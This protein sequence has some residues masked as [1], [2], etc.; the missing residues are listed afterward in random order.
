MVSARPAPGPASVLLGAISCKKHDA[1]VRMALVPAFFN[2]QKSLFQG[3]NPVKKFPCSIANPGRGRG[4][5]R[6]ALPYGT[7]I[8]PCH[9]A[10]PYEK[11]HEIVSKWASEKSLS[12]FEVTPRGS[13]QFYVD[14]DLS[15]RPK[16]R[17][18]ADFCIIRARMR[19]NYF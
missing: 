7:A 1:Y 16:H 3:Q 2:F 8:W 17:F 19:A 15:R 9:M 12:T 11:K 13:F 14:L 10:L 5:G 18:P 4:G 6:M